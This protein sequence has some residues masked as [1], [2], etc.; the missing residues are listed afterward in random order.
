MR[1][2]LV[3]IILFVSVQQTF[4]CEICGCSSGNYFIGPFPQ[5][6]KHFV[7]LRYSFRRFDTH[8]ATDKDQFSRDFYQTAELWGGYNI[9]RKWQILAFVPFNINKQ[10]TDDGVMKSSGLGDISLIANY[11]IF[12][13]VADTKK[14][15]RV[16]QQLWIGGGLKLPTGKFAADQDNIIADANNQAGTGS[17]DVLANAMYSLHIGNWGLNTN[18]NYRINNQASSFKF[19]DRFNSSAFVFRTIE[20]GSVSIS[21]NIGLT[22]EYLSANKLDKVKVEDTGGNSLLGAGG[23]EIGFNKVVLGTNIQLPIAQN[24]SNGQTKINVKGMVHVTFLF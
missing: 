10:V 17:V 3:S 13:K 22:Y 8:L 19:G 5:F 24:L 14:G 23:V 16:T 15:N 18:I 2:L 7:S 12:N 20:A 11:K 1:R 4:A 6:K 9:G 21:P